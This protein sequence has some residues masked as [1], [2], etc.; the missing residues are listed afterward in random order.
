VKIELNK[1]FDIKNQ[2]NFGW[3]KLPLKFISMNIT[4]RNFEPFDLELV[5]S[6]LNRL[7]LKIV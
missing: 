2:F 6:F 1:L 7:D 5:K 4:G 3:F